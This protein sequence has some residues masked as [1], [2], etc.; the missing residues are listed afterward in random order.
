[1]KNLLTLIFILF[2]TTSLTAQD[3]PREKFR[4]FNRN[5]EAKGYIVNNIYNEKMRDE[6]YDKKTMFICKW[7]STYKDTIAEYNVM[8]GV[9]N[10]NG[11]IL[12]FEDDEI[13]FRG[14]YK[15]IKQSKTKIYKELDRY[16][17]TY[18]MREGSKYDEISI[19][20]TTPFFEGWGS[21][22]N[23]ISFIILKKGNQIRLHSYYS[24][25]N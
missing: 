10:D 18:V 7:Y 20:C 23:G 15:E 9:I 8:P 24:I 13:Y 25:I 6:T 14:V 2:I 21:A 16:K 12:E 17:K 5:K 1:M 11:V 4:K 3:W 19:Y 22:T